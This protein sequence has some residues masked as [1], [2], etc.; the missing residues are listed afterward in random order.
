[1]PGHERM[2]LTSDGMNGPDMSMR[3]DMT[4]LRRPTLSL[5]P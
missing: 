2:T 3:P 5:M 4:V 1:M